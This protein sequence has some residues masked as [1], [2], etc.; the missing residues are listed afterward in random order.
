[1]KGSELVL[2]FPRLA[3]GRRRL[4]ERDDGQDERRCHQQ[5]AQE[6]EQT[7]HVVLPFVNDGDSITALVWAGTKQPVRRPHSPGD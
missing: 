5:A 3:P 1:V 7:F 4:D 2:R 6:C